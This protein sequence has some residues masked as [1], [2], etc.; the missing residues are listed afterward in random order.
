ML[1]KLLRKIPGYRLLTSPLIRREYWR[2]SLEDCHRMQFYGGLLASGDLVFDIGANMGNRSKAFLMLGAR[3]VAF[4]PQRECVDYLR[5]AAGHHPGFTLVA[6]ALGDRSG[7]AEMLVSDDHVI[8]TLSIPWQQATLASGRFGKARWD[9]SQMVIID[10]LAQAIMEY[11][12][13]KFVK[14]DVEGFEYEVVST[15]MHPIAAMSIEF[16]SEYLESTVRCVEHFETLADN[17]VYQISIEES[18]EFS[19]QT[20]VSATELLD[21]LQGLQPGAWGDLYVRMGPGKKQ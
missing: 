13:P 19:L 12:M 5:A 11:G 16:T 8:S 20:W 18:M 14:I 3:V 15:L 1:R 6:K 17:N 4:E 21:T 9:R 2:I 7:L 10:T